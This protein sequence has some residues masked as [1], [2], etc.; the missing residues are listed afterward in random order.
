MA[1]GD[2]VTAIYEDFTLPGPGGRGDSR[3]SAA[4]MSVGEIVPTLERAPLSNP[5]IVDALGGG[6]GA[7]SV[8][9][10]V[11]SG[12]RNE[13]AGR[14]SGASLRSPGA[15]LERRHRES[16]L[17][18]LL[19]GGRQDRKP[20]ASWTPGAVGN[21]TASIFVWESPDNPAA[22]L[23]SAPVRIDVE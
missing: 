21:Y 10:Q 9:Q 16:V 1:E 8:G 20:A 13:R 6:I 2:T 14:G 17:V 23:P 18:Y 3:E 12:G 4:V 7:A 11:Q 15:G 5:R 22:L 19:S